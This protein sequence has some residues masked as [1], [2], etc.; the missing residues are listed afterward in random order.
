MKILGYEL[1]RVVN[2]IINPEKEEIGKFTIITQASQRRTVD[3]GDY[4]KALQ[5]AESRR[6]PL[7]YALYDQ[8][9]ESIDYVPHLKALLELRQLNLLSKEFRF[10]VNGVVDES[11]TPWIQSPEFKNFLRD[12]LD[13]KFWGFSL[14]DFTD[15]KGE[16]FTYDLINRKH[17]DPI[18]EVV[19][20][21][22]NGTSPIPYNTNERLKYVLPVG[23]KT[24]LGLLKNATPI[25]IHIRNMTGDMMNYV[26][27][28]GNN[29]TVYK[30][31]TGDP[32]IAT[33]IGQ[34]EKNKSGSGY[35]QVPA[36]VEREIENQSS[37]Q[38]NELFK[39]VHDLLNKE[40][41]KL[42]LGSTMGIEDGSS[43]SQ[44][45]VHERTMGKGISI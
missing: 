42:I 20:K 3:I 17:V 35:V 5:L 31:K 29:F 12:I 40:L 43:L 15:S 28:A 24:D 4:I 44:A 23:N 45:E 33:Q 11:M 18:T 34:A 1:N 13:T 41:S 2:K 27:L 9:Q 22:Q 6:K 14:F 32:K 37:S 38:Q 10:T 21:Y 36:G 39:G 8:Y 16:W 19:Y 25:A 26:E 7:R 30:D